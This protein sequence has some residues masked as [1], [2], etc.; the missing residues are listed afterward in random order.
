MATGERTLTMSGEETNLR[1]LQPSHKQPVTGDVFAMQLPGGHF[2]FGRVV[3]TEAVIGP[4]KDAILIYIYDCQFD[5]RNVPSRAELSPRRL[6]VSPI[7]TNRLPWTKGY[8][9]TVA[10]WPIEAGDLLPQHCFLSAARGVYFDEKG[11]QLPGP[12]E[13]VG[14]WGLHSY[15][16]ID[17]EISDALSLARTTD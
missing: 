8:F 11:N 9:E 3:S 14:D 10:H 12:I 6:L 2:L 13:P 7:M 5:S 1:V 4:M 15:R 16:T 17:D